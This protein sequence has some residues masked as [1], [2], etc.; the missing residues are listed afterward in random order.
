[1]GVDRQTDMCR[2]VSGKETMMMVVVV[3]VVEGT[4]NGSRQADRH[5]ETFPRRATA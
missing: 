2:H 3:V 4:R 1:M 5:V